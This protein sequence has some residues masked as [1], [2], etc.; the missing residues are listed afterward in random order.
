[1]VLARAYGLSSW[2]ALKNHVEGVN[3]AALLAAAEAGD[4]AAVR[5]LAKVRPDLVNPRLA[6]FRDS[7]LHR[8]VLRRNEELARVLMQLGADARVGIWPHR[9]ATSAYAIAVDREY[10]EIVATIEREE[11]NRRARLG[12]E[13]TST[14]DAVDALRQAIAGGCTAEAIT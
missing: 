9:D 5:R 7:A 3:F 2:A 6:E 10:S 12:S 14:G 11:D 1:R 4:V 13:G 8:A